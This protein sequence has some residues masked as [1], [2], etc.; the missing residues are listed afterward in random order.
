MAHIAILGAGIGGLSAAYELKDALGSKHKITVVNAS[1]TFQFVP[2]NPWLAVG[3][4][5]REQTQYQRP[6]CAG[7]RDA[8]QDFQVSLAHSVRA[9]AT[10]PGLAP[11]ARAAA[12]LRSSGARFRR[13]PD[14]PEWIPRGLLGHTA[15]ENRR[16]Q[17]KS[18]IPS[19]AKMRAGTNLTQ[20]GVL[21]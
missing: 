5:Q 7:P 4:R 20:I 14:A 6:A 19:Y 11:L 21:N 12:A 16:S 13:A 2:S 9:G 10:I 8:R 1:E 17:H 18:L 15:I 3:W